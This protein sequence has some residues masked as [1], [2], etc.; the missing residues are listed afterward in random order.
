MSEEVRNGGFEYRES[1]GYD[2]AQVDSFI[3]E[4]KKYIAGQ[5]NEKQL[6]TQKLHV[7]AVK[8]Q[9]YQALEKAQGTI[10]E[11]NAA[12]KAE[13]G[14]LENGIASLKNEKEALEAEL[15]EDKANLDAQKAELAAVEARLGSAKNE[16]FA[17]DAAIKAKKAA[18][19]DYDAKVAALA[20]EENRI[21]NV[22]A[23]EINTAT[24]ETKSAVT[25]KLVALGS[26]VA[27]N[28]AEIKS[29]LEN[30]T[31]VNVA[32]TSAEPVASV[33]EIPVAE[34]AAA[35][36]AAESVLTVEDLLAEEDEVEET[37]P[38]D[39]ELRSNRDTAR[40]ILRSFAGVDVEEDEDATTKIMPEGLAEMELGGGASVDIVINA[41]N[42][43]E[44][45]DEIGWCAPEGSAD[46]S[47]EPITFAEEVAAEA[48]TKEEAPVV[49]VLTAEEAEGLSYDD[50]LALVMKKN[51]IDYTPAKKAQAPVEEKAEQKAEEPVNVDIP[52]DEKPKK[53]K[54]GFFAAL[55]RNIDAILDDD[56]DEEDDDEFNGTE[57]FTPE[58][59][60]GA[61]NEEKPALRFGR[62]K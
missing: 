26:A 42:G 16:A 33:V 31:V 34:E 27:A 59:K 14:E 11:K 61:K 36:P 21:M 15:K 25:E 40:S 29:I 3:N 54:K 51:G 23:E 39:E 2:R 1:G 18:L 58:N 4:V 37:E 57:V 46:E 60:K 30:S 19:A 41:A 13:A 45:E 50:A 12:L 32:L 53:E 6:L 47:D 28:I 7:L 43:A 8:I 48:E 56:E 17:L 62:D 5:K 24:A 55:K 52:L 38:T 35:E 44:T 9:E 20:A 10:A 22:A 49:A